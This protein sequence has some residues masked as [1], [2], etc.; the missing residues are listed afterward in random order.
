LA[1][2]V[3]AVA[4]P[5][6]AQGYPVIA[7]AKAD[8]LNIHCAVIGLIA[9]LGMKARQ[10]MDLSEAL[11]KYSKIGGEDYERISRAII[12]AAYDVPRYSVDENKEAAIM[13]FKND[14]RRDC[15]KVA[16]EPD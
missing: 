7:G 5:A 15:L 8:A 10:N 12:L 4:L 11:P 6:S 14:W 16:E 2:L 1:A 3:M 9:H 13:D